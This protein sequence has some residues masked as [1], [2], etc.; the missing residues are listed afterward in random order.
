MPSHL[1]NPWRAL[2][3]GKPMGTE[4]FQDLKNV[5]GQLHCFV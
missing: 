4:R 5:V 1:V 3:I 2:C